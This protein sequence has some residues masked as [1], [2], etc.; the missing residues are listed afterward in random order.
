MSNC[1]VYEY[2]VDGCVRYVGKGRNRRAD[3]HRKIATA[4]NERRAAGESVRATRW[5]NFL[6][7]AL[8]EGRSV[9][10][11]RV[12]AELA[13]EQAFAK[14]IE[15]IARYGRV[16]FDGGLLYNELAGGDGTTSADMKRLANAK[17]IAALIG[18]FPKAA[19]RQG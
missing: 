8:R 16:G 17:T 14:E 6:A 7:Q 4:I 13:D 10:V 3:A 12:S 1:Y 11:R 9:E 2:H 5:L 18:E 19:K 15:L